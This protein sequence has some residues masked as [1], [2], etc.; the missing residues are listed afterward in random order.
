MA[1]P[2]HYEFYVWRIQGVDPPRM[3]PEGWAVS[4][5]CGWIDYGYADPA[6]AH[7]AFARHETPAPAPVADP[8]P[9][10]ER[11][12]AVDLME[13]LKRSLAEAMADRLARSADPAP[14]GER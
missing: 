2:A 8:A 10:P 4:C 9:E 5:T 1:E 7:G 11:P 12:K 13:A 14:E 3:Y 6:E